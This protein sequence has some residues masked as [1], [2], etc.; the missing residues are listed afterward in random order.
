MILLTNQYGISI[1]LGTHKISIR[2]VDLL[3]KK[4]QNHITIDNPQSRFGIDIVNRARSTLS[5]SIDLTSELHDLLNELILQLLRHTHVKKKEISSCILVGNTVMHHIMFGLPLAPLLH[6]PY[7]SPHTGYIHETGGSI[8]L[9]SISDVSCY[10]PPLIGSFV[11]SDTI[12][13]GVSSSIFSTQKTTLAIDIGANSEFLLAHEG[14]IVSTSAASGPA[15][16]GM[17][18]E[19]GT[20]S[21]SGAIDSIKLDLGSSRVEYSTIDSKNPVGI[22]GTGAISALAEFVRNGIITEDGS[23]NR[24]IE[25]PLLSLVDIPPYFN[26]TKNLFIS[27]YD[28]RMLQQSKS[29]IHAAIDTI[30]DISKCATADIECLI[31][32]GQFGSALNLQDAIDID[33]LPDF[34]HASVSR[35]PYAANEGA[36]EILFD[37]DLRESM[38]SLISKVEYIDLMNNELFENY[39][40][41]ALKYTRVNR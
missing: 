31:L 30:L 23:F 20:S 40:I 13:L 6:E 8:G 39:Y 17:S 27:Q 1:D 36:E 41:Q 4:F 37:L 16:E 7:Q 19:C 34:T 9:N 2:L 33:M 22:C 24:L 18:L 11:G 38:D 28:L 21:V 26:I 14:R 32:G 10:S 25:S 5:E 29:A 15:F 12:A 35:R 3:T